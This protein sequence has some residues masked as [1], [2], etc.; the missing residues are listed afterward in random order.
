MRYLRLLFFILFLF[1]PV[2]TWGQG[3]AAVDFSQDALI[4]K[5]A[6]DAVLPKTDGTSGSVLKARQGKKAIL[7]FWATWCPHCYDEIGRI[8]DVSPEV[9][10]KAIKIILVDSGE[11]KEAVKNY[12]DQRQIKLDCFIDEESLFQEPYRLVGVP[13]MFFIDEKGLIRNV[14]HQFPADYET[15]F[16][17]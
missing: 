11:S 15:Y 2:I 7:V 6:A 8:N 16:R 13:T 10:K 3:Q 1:S 5:P 4:G 9:Q 12:L 17:S 14:T